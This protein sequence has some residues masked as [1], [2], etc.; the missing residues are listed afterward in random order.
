MV[1]PQIQGP[2]SRGRRARLRADK[3][4]GGE[5]R[6]DEPAAEPH[7]RASKAAVPQGSAQC[8]QSAAYFLVPLVSVSA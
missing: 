4:R 5:E 3:A 8:S 1:I 2:A 7:L 6:K